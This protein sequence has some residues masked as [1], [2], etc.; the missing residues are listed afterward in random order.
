MNKKNQ[1]N[2]YVLPSKYGTLALYEK[3]GG[4]FL[5]WFEEDISQSSEPKKKEFGE[6]DVEELGEVGME[7]VELL[8]ISRFRKTDCLVIKIQIG[9]SYKLSIIDWESGEY[10]GNIDLESDSNVHSSI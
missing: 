8:D 5:D 3:N 6:I 10:L 7:F 4:M 2:L 9:K 1:R